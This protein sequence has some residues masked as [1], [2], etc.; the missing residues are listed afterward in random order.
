MKAHLIS[1]VVVSILVIITAAIMPPIP[2]STEYHL[3]A[4]QRS[5]FGIPNFL[6]VISNLSFLISG[7]AGMFFLSENTSNQRIFNDAIESVPY[8]I[9]FLSVVALGFGSG[10]YHWIPNTDNLVWDRLPLAITLAALLSA[11]IME[12]ISIRIGLFSLLPLVIFAIGSVFYWYWT[13]LQNEGNLNFYGVMQ[14]YSIILI[15]WISLRFTSPYAKAND[16][17]LII[18]FYGIAK[19]AEILDW[20]I[21]GITSETLSGH[22]LK[23]LVAGYAA[24]RIVS[25]L[26]KRETEL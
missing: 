5:F 17:F 19:V 13:E 21:Y 11:T 15:I 20:Q 10:F 8:W 1:I 2:Q 14:F 7:C 9:L 25:M 24:Y 6:N 12:R 3:F 18:I 22:T 26:R 16:I 4:D 23:H